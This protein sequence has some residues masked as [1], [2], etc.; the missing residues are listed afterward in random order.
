M[1]LAVRI[2]VTG[3]PE[4][5]PTLIPHH[6]VTDPAT[7]EVYC[8]DCGLVDASRGP[9]LF[10]GD[11]LP[12]DA[13]TA[14]AA[15]APMWSRAAARSRLEAVRLERALRIRS[16]VASR[17]ERRGGPRRDSRVRETARDVAVRAGL[18]RIAEQEAIVLAH[19]LMDARRHQIERQDVEALTFIAARKLG[20]PVTARSFAEA[21]GVRSYQRRLSDGSLSR[22]VPPHV[23]LLRRVSECSRRLRLGL[24]PVDLGL[25]AREAC[26]ALGL[27]PA[28]AAR[29]AAA[30]PEASSDAWAGSGVGSPLAMLAALIYAAATT[31]GMGPVRSQDAIATAVRVTPVSIRAHVIRAREWLAAARGPT[32]P[33]RSRGPSPPSDAGGS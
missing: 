26:G 2:T 5:F 1:S 11:L 25:K 14:D 10:G 15:G 13:L 16:R 32:G 6:P 3:P 4:P 33:P 20:L 18:P 9:P 27:P 17:R 8:A 29:V 28:F 23:M 19:A 7:G 30:I 24:P 31:E 22:E 12:A 21:A